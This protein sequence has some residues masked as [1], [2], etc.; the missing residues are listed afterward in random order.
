MTSNATRYSKESTSHH[1][2]LLLIVPVVQPPCGRLTSSL[3]VVSVDRL[4][5]V[6]SEG[7]TVEQAQALG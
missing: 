1:P 4:A 2:V 7:A 6:H 5:Q 3:A